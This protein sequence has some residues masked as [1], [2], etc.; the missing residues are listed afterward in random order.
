MALNLNLDQL[1]LTTGVFNHLKNN[2][3]AYQLCG[4]YGCSTLIW[5][6][7]YFI[8]FFCKTH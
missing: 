2:F 8:D 3:V 1:W 7:V 4:T 6:Q 5:K